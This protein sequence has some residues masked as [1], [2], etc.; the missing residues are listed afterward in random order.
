MRRLTNPRT[1]LYK[2][3]KRLML[4]PEF[5]W[6]FYNECCVDMKDTE[7]TSGHRNFSFFSNVILARPGTNG[8]KYPVSNFEHLDT[9]GEMLNQIWD[10][11]NINVNCI[12]RI[13]ANLVYPQA[14]IQASPIHRDHEFP[15]KNLLIYLT[16][17]GGKTV[18]GKDE[19]NPQE[20]DIIEFGG[21]KH[22]YYLPLEKPR[23]VL[24]ATYF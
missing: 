15:H 4:S 14:G 13:N 16:D 10:Y 3:I 5:T 21:F 18:C 9:I 7:V 12:F 1:D 20:D 17:A 19:H 22:Y 6:N 2:N 11:N 8:L 23:V 24:V